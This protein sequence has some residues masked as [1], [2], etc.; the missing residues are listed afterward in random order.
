LPGL[1]P[2]AG[3]ANVASRDP[4]PNGEPGNGAAA[5]TALE[6]NSY[7]RWSPPFGES[8]AVADPIELVVIDIVD[9]VAVRR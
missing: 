2:S 3:S 5:T 6:R 8:V 4:D 1:R 7:L 9:I